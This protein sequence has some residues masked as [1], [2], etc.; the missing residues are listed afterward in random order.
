[1]NRIRI[2]LASGWLLLALITGGGASCARHQPLS[3]YLPPPTVFNQTPSTAQLAELI[4]RTDQVSRMQSN[5]ATVQVTTMPS[6]PRLSAN[7]AMQR[8]QRI[9]IQAAIPMLP[10]SGLDLGSNDQKY[11]MKVP[12][13]A[14]GQLYYAPQQTNA[15]FPSEMLSVEPVW[16]IDA[17]GLARIDL[18][19]PHSEPILASDGL[20][21]IRSPA[22]VGGTV[23]QRLLRIDSKSG[24]IR[25]QILT[26]N[27]GRLRARAVADGFEYY[28]EGQFALP[29]RVDL[30]LYVGGQPLEMQIDVSRWVVNQLLT[31]DA[32]LFQMPRRFS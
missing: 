5:S 21:E 9:R 18:G 8:S 11:W 13:M 1:M 3:V 27:D 17:L 24:V 6:L 23:G 15:P 26:G 29:H 16:L 2:I 31:D 12:A 22:I 19:V 32:N 10:G 14:G 20:L 28:P 25:Q 7:I 30:Q 4:N